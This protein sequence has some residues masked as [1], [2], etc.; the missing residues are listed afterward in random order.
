MTSQRKQFISGVLFI[1][2]VLCISS[3]AE[4]TN[5][6]LRVCPDNPRYF[7]DTDGKAILLVGSHVW[8]NLVDM[9]PE[10]PPKPFDYEAYLDWMGKYDHNFMRMWAWEMTQWDTKPNGAHA[11]Q[12]VTRFYVK[13][14]PWLRCGDDKALDG[15]PKFDLTKFDPVYFQRLRQ[16]IEPA[17]Q[18]GIYVSI[19]LF[20]G[21]AMQNIEGGFKL[22]PFHPENNIN[23]V[24]GDA[25]GDGK[26]LE[27]HELVIDAVTEI[28]KAYIR[29]VVDTV[30]DL[31]NVL[32][33]ISNENHPESTRWQYA[34]IRY[35]HEYEKGKPAQHPVGMTFQYKGGKNQDLFNSPADWIS[36]NPESGYRDNPPANNGE[37]VILTDTDHLWGIGGNQAWVWKSLTRSLNPLFMDPYDGVVLG[38]RFDPN[39]D[40]IRRSMGYARKFSQRMNL[41]KCKPAAKDYCLANPGRQYLVYQP[42]AGDPVKLKLGPAEYSFEWFDPSSGKTVATGKI[43]GDENKETTFSNP[44]KADAVLYVHLAESR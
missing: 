9:G 42:T 7:A 14:H 18:K 11:R 22:H 28:Q 33:E 12:D 3:Y 26:G 24:N 8:Y 37:K 5:G 19:M 1:A 41:N 43:Y 35:I 17:Q 20:E 32:F 2:T 39:F 6:P 25:N 10:D 38:R 4:P 15:K 29:K 36:P 13:P 44:V 16:R 21:W 23:G 30:N 27:V 31:D 40:T 34:M